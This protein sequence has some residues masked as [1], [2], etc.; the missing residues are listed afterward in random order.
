MFNSPTVFVVAVITDEAYAAIEGQTLT[1]QIV[2]IVYFHFSHNKTNP[3][4]QI[5]CNR[6]RDSIYFS[7]RTPK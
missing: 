4:N 3:T 7:P 1:Y 6:S 5:I 2:K